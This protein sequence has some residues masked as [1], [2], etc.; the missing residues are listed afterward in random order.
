[1]RPSPDRIFQVATRYSPGAAGDAA[2]VSAGPD[3][4]ASQSSM[5]TTRHHDP[6]AARL[7]V[8]IGPSQ[9]HP[10]RRRFQ[11]GRKRAD[12]R[13]IGELS[14]GILT[15]EVRLHNDDREKFFHPLNLLTLR[16][17]FDNAALMNR[18]PGG[19][20]SRTASIE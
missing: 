5:D 8:A 3:R 9:P 12:R 15:V 18:P 20:Y 17:R 6:I 2:A 1:Q 10:D 4:A 13:V 7:R 14:G 19:R 16:S 11:P